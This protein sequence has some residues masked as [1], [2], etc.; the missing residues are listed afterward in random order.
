MSLQL[1]HGKIAV[2]WFALRGIV[3]RVAFKAAR[4]RGFRAGV[5][6]SAACGDAWQK[7]IGTLLAR[8]CSSVAACAVH[9]P[10]LR[11]IEI[12]VG[13][14]ARRNI[15]RRNFRPCGVFVRNQRVALFASFSPQELLVLSCALRNPLRRSEQSIIGGNGFFGQVAARI[16]RNTQIF[17]MNGNV[18]LQLGDNQGMNHFRLVVWSSVCEPLVELQGMAG[19][20]RLRVSCRRHISSRNSR[21]V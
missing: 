13:Q 2:D 17:R 18:G 3:V 6:A 21:I 4:F 16:A 14:I 19:R 10:V 7:H 20:A 9:K 8:Q 12:R 1:R 15:G 5:M 11:V